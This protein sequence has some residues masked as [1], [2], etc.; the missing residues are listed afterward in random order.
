MLEVSVIIC[1]H[2]PRSEYLD[3]VLKALRN[4]TLPKDRWEILI[5]D[6]ASTL[7]LAS[8]WDLCWHPNSRHII[9]SEL[10]LAPARR[11][12]IREGAA[13]LLVFVD[14]D[15]VLDENYLSE[16]LKIERD[17]PMLGVWGSGSTIP[18]YEL[19]PPEHLK[20]FVPYLALRETTTPRWSN[21][22]SCSDAL[23]WG[24]GLCV[25]SSVATA[26]REFY[27]QS[28]IRITGRQGKTLSSGEDIEISFVSCKQGL[29][30]GVFPELKLTHLIPK[31]RISEKYLVNIAE[32]AALSGLLLKYKWDA[33]IPRSPFCA[34]GMAAILRSILIDS[35]MERRVYFAWVRGLLQARKIIAAQSRASVKAKQS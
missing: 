15:N 19:K 9:E 31:E 4:Q 16:A 35:K 11:R 34:R 2:N 27:E 12:G 5:V 20:K 21:V 3:R 24:A 17:W 8:R 14:D 28:L 30:M 29:G 1:S 7:P 6:N 10:G 32:G 25:R 26:Y 33:V 13:D 22:P 23:P 18:D